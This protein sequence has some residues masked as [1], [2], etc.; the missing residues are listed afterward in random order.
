MTVPDL[1]IL[2]D[3]LLTMAGPEADH[4]QGVAIVG[5]RIEDDAPTVFLE[6]PE[7]K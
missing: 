2:S 1:I 5:D 4:M 3:R 6:N 7:D